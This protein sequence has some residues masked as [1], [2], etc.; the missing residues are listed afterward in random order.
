MPD[1]VDAPDVTPHGLDEPTLPEPL[2]EPEPPVKYATDTPVTASTPTKATAARRF[3]ERSFRNMLVY[4]RS[5][6]PKPGRIPTDGG[7]FSGSSRSRAWHPCSAGLPSSVACPV[8]IGCS[9]ERFQSPG[10][11]FEAELTRVKELLSALSYTRCVILGGAVA[12]LALA[13]TAA[14]PGHAGAVGPAR[15]AAAPQ[16]QTPTLLATVPMDSTGFVARPGFMIFDQNRPNWTADYLAGP[17]LTQQGFQAGRQP[18]IVWTHWGSR[19]VGRASYW[20]GYHT[21]C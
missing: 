8:P 9:T 4:L 15:G 6:S 19:A 10:R 5:Q 3:W 2:T 17:N 1:Q 21:S 11:M 7:A 14:A 16:T 13:W 12:L 20:I 18:P